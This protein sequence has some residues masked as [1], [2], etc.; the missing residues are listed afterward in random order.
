MTTEHPMRFGV[1]ASPG[2]DALALAQAAEKL[3]YDLIAVPQIPI[4]SPAPD[5]RST[6]VPAAVGGMDGLDSW[7]LLTWIAGRTERIGLLAAGL[8]LGDREPAVLARAA[9]S[10]D[11]LSGGRLE[12]AFSAAGGDGA[13]V[14]AGVGE[15]VEVVRGVLDAGEAGPLRHLGK[16]Y[17]VPNAQRGPLPAHRIPIV[18]SGD[19]VRM[20]RL[21]GRTADGWWELGPAGL[22]VAGK[23]VD[24]AAVEAGR[25]A[26]EV[27][28]IAV[29]MPGSTAA[30]LMALGADTFLVCTDDA[31]ELRRFAEETMAGLRRDAPAPTIIRPSS[32]RAKRRPGIDYDN[33]P[34]ALAGTAVEP[35][36]LDYARVR[37]TYMRGGS[38]GLV[39]RPRD[40]AEVVAALAH[41]RAHPELPIGLRSGGH[42]VSGR[43][44]NDGG[45]VISL[46][47]LNSIEIVDEARR[48]VRVGAGARWTDVAD[49]LLPYGWALSSG[50]YGGVGVGGLATAGGVG[51]LARKHGLTIDHLRAV[52]MVLADG[53]VVRASAD[54][55]ADLFWAVRGAGGN[56]GVVTSFEFEVDEV[57]KVGFA[58]L[59][60]A[61][62]DP[63]E[64]LV[65]WGR[66][67]E[68]APRDLSGQLIMGPPRAGQ[69]A[70]AQLMGVVDAEDPETIIDQLQPIAAVAPLYQQNVTLM[71]YA[72]VMANAADGY[73]QGAGDPVSR[74]GLIAHLTP[75]FARAAARV[76]ASGAVHWFQIR[77]VGGAVA[78]VPA[79]DTA[80]AH[81]SANF[82]VI[83]MGSSKRRVD[84]AWDELYPHF[85]GLYLSFETDQSPARVED[86]FPP[87]TLA[88]L[89]ELKRR[90]DPGNL[91]RDNFNILPEGATR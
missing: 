36:D 32:V 76:L 26:A 3:G 23:V 80:Y 69:P 41:V 7:T 2:P 49:A 8:A 42:G 12:L 52:E 61:A 22:A 66:A 54:E 90:Y 81:R 17:R 75:E 18:L 31:G 68:A 67:I 9:A 88:R 16:H 21:A 48:L 73:H 28:R 27:R 60:V 86:A 19:S 29:V 14:V 58:Q 37:S 5:S 85:E 87:A 71:P 10:L 11:L 64:L 59:V 62:D 43:S 84:A 89:R 46:A 39:L 55:N 20:A 57:G 35:G 47:A 82:S 63:A 91:F 6:A 74:S 83:V 38:P 4:A 1:L 53:S 79:G 78:D 25:D 56:F 50:D 33:L 40:T 72:G 15:F 51:W 34:A 70:F 65:K 30:E 45:L 77:T 44:T 24:E 13:E